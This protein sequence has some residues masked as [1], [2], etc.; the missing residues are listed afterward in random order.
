MEKRQAAQIEVWSERLRMLGV[1]VL[2]G[3]GVGFLAAIA[4]R[5]IMRIVALALGN[6]PMFTVANLALIRT[7]LYDG[8]LMGLLFVAIRTYL[9][10]GR[11][12]KGLVFGV[13]LLALASLPF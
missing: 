9:P 6:P 3:L 7:G 2:S 13:L 12:V 1:G 8:V 5:V 10:G 11:I 4:A